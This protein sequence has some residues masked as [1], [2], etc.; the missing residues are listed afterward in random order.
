MKEAV[1]TSQAVDKAYSLISSPD[2]PMIYILVPSD[3]KNIASGAVS[4]LLIENFSNANFQ[5]DISQLSLTNEVLAELVLGKFKPLLKFVSLEK[6]DIVKKVVCVGLVERS[7]VNIAELLPTSSI[8]N[9]LSV[10]SI[11]TDLPLV[12]SIIRFGSELEILTLPET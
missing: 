5:V 6:V 2:L 3:L 7:V 8:L 12:S 9:I 1:V 10:I 4:S 11:S